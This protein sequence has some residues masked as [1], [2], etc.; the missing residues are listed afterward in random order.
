MRY[1]IIENSGLE[2]ENTVASYDTYYLAIN[3]M[4]QMFSPEEIESQT[5]RLCY[6]DEEGKR[7]YEL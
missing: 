6:E 5:I 1:L 7:S 3:S 4:Y 2:N